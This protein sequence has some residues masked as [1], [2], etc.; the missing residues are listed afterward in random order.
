ME[1]TTHSYNQLREAIVA[2]RATTEQKVATSTQALIIEGYWQI[3]QTLNSSPLIQTSQE[4]TLTKLAT[5]LQ[6]ERSTLYRTMQFNKQWSELCPT[7]SLPALS[8]SHYK[9]LLP[10]T[11]KDKRNSLA[12]KA[13]TEK[14][15]I[16]M[17]SQKIKEDTITAIETPA[18]T[19]DET[20]NLSRSENKLHIYR[21]SVAHVVDGDT[22]VVSI[23]LGFDVWTKKRIR[24]RGIDTAEKDTDD[25]KKAKQFVEAALPLGST[26][27]VQTFF[28][29]LHGRY[30][31]D[32]F[33][34]AG[35][36]DKE[37]ILT[38]GT[39]LNQQLLNEGLAKVL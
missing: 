10:L 14:W 28:T 20:A 4:A 8:W 22:L 35:S 3:G 21:A 25:G 34:L 24:L 29:D 32:V 17:L 37:K 19:D 36:T 12:K 18:A 7:Q 16:R 15:P 27:V 26:I 11:D 33:Y 13:N 23:D 1:I 38:D 5:D 6:I 30:V 9:T 2:I 31:G 39:F